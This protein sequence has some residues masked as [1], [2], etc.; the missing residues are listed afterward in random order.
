MEPSLNPFVKKMWKGY[1]GS[2]GCVPINTEQ[3]ISMERPAP[4]IAPAPRPRAPRKPAPEEVKA[5]KEAEARQQMLAAQAKKQQQDAQQKGKPEEQI[6]KKEECDAEVCEKPPVFDL[7]DIPDAMQKMGWPVSGTIARRWF[8]SPKH[9]YDD[10]PVSVQPI[11]DTSV[12]LD[13]VLRFG[14]VRD[15]Y[16]KLLETEIYKDA[17]RQLAKKYIKRKLDELFVQQGAISL[18]FNTTPYTT[19]LRQFHIDWQF[20][21][22]AVSNWDGMDGLYL[23]DLTGALANFAIF[24]GIGNVDIVGERYYRYDREK[25]TKAYCVDAT[26]GITHVY[27]YVKDN[28]SFND[29]AGSKKSQYLGHWNKTGVI[30]TNG[31]LISELVDGKAIHTD[32]GNS[33][34]TETRIKWDYLL[35]NPLDK[36][37]DR[38]TGIFKKFKEKDVYFPVYNKTYNEWRD[39]NNR[40]GDFMIYSK[41]KYVKLGKPIHIKLETLCRAPESM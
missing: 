21:K 38:R 32:M 8:C 26:A 20:Q 33:S 27:V 5:Q 31:G 2:E 36:P 24:V 40:G 6:K 35:K 7:Q 34:K 39:K 3:A 25:K 16:D 11:D 22:M 14:N 28:Y 29:E 19:D 10:D 4:G 18:S 23:T 13:W 12:T 41:P 15:K 17:A 37:V 9:I 1:Y 30:L